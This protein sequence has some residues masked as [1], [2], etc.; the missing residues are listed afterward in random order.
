MQKDPL[1]ISRTCPVVFIPLLVRTYSSQSGT[2]PKVHYL[3]I[4]LYQDQEPIS[5][6]NDKI[7]VKET[8]SLLYVN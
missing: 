4:F 6:K 2:G 5:E 1:C 8:A 3:E 7:R